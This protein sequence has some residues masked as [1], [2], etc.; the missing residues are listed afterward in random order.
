VA[1][2]F[3]KQHPHALA[4]N[5]LQG[6][7][8]L[9]HAIEEQDEACDAAH[10]EFKPIDITGWLSRRPGCPLRQNSVTPD[11][12]K[13]QNGEANCNRAASEIGAH[14]HLLGG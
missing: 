12:L 8:E 7:R 2:S 3:V 14:A 6:F 4:G 1:G 11:Q 9:G 10:R 5:L 13:Q